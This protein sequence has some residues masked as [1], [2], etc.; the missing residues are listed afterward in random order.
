[1]R[2][3]FIETSFIIPISIKNNEK[4]FDKEL[5]FNKENIEIKQKHFTIEINP[6]KKS[7]KNVSIEMINIYHRKSTSLLEINF[8]F[9]EVIKEPDLTIDDILDIIYFL[10]ENYRNQK[11]YSILI[12][13]NRVTLDEFLL[14]TLKSKNIEIIFLNN[15]RKVFDPH[16]YNIL[17]FN[18]D[19]NLE[20]EDF[21]LSNRILLEQ[22][23]EGTRQTYKR[24][25]VE[26]KREFREFSNILWNINEM[27]CTVG[28]IKSNED[29]SI[30]INNNFH[31]ILK[32]DYKNYFIYNLFC[33]YELNYYEKVISEL[34]VFEESDALEIEEKNNSSR[35]LILKF[36]EFRQRYLQKNIAQ[37]MQ[38]Q[39]V[40]EHIKRNFKIDQQVLS[41]E[42]LINTLEKT[43][44]LLWNEL[45]N[46]R[47]EAE[48]KATN[49]RQRIIEIIAIFI[50]SYEAFK[51]IYDIIK[52]LM[53]NLSNTLFIFL[54]TS[55][56]TAIVVFIVVKTMKKVL[57][58]VD[59]NKEERKWLNW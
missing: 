41:S 57:N 11:R 47:L 55:L 4:F 58:A 48:I 32:K 37:N 9:R 59:K 33:L 13:G 53:I 35:K 42:N 51:V 5:F 36:Y 24:D 38:Q 3:D 17:F 25:S 27:S 49:K 50:G 31:S 23:T 10:K 15:N 45:E 56:V 12:D 8:S 34:L 30:F 19:D 1:M 52:D 44:N 54:I 39:R 20:V 46:I 29:N 14:N 22:F 40:I 6:L 26:E 2:Y 16:L 43:T 28:V 21:N 18:R 7:Y